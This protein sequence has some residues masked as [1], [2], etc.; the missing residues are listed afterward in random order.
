MIN[1]HI[2]RCYEPPLRRLILPA[3]SS[4]NTRGTQICSDVPQP[5][6]CQHNSR[7]YGTFIS[8]LPHQPGK[9]AKKEGMETRSLRMSSHP[10]SGVQ[11]Q[12]ALLLLLQSETFSWV[13]A[14]VSLR[15][16]NITPPHELEQ[17][18]TQIFRLAARLLYSSR[19]FRS[20]SKAVIVARL[21]LHGLL[22]C[23]WV[24]TF[25]RLD[26]WVN[27]SR[28]SPPAIDRPREEP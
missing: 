24:F 25:S 8:L 7:P 12:H 13:S 10:M 23:S 9:D 5:R 17:C 3:A 26:N 21:S 18:N 6:L 1:S 20:Y 16:W 19:G 4:P 22:L 15:V 27:V 28:L 2:V 14:R 11:K